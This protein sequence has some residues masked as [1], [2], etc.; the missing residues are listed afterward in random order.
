MRAG[1]QPHTWDVR[2]RRPRRVPVP[3]C[4]AQEG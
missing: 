3:V 4:S 1:V 2:K